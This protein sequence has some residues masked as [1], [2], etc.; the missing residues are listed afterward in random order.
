MK[1][2]LQEL[3]IS[4]QSFRK[5]RANNYLYVDKTKEIFKLAKNEKS[6]FLSRP[7][8]FGKSLLVSTLEN[9]FLGKKELFKDLYIYDKWDWNKTHPVI[10]IDLGGRT[11]RSG[12]K[13]KNSLNIF[14]TKIAKE[15]DI[16][17]EYD[18]Y[19][20]KFGEL[21]ESLVNK[22]GKVVVLIDEYDK[23]ILDN[24]PY[25]NIRNE[26]K[27]VLHDFYQILKSQDDNLRFVFLT[28][29]SKFVGTSIFSGLNNLVDITLSNKFSTICGYTQNELE[30]Y[31]KSYITNLSKEFNIN[32]E[33]A[34]LSIKEWYNGYSWDGKNFVYN[35]QST[36][37]LFG[38]MEFNNYWFKTGTPTFL[39]ELLKGKN[40][41]NK[42]FSWVK[43]GSEIVDAYDPENIPL[44]PLMFQTGY[45]TINEK[46]ITDLRINYLLNIPN[47]EVRD[48][49]IK[50]LMNISMDYPLNQVNSLRNRMRKNF[51]NKN[52]EDLNNNL[53]EMLASIP[54]KL[55]NNNEA[56]FHS[57]FLIWLNLL[58]FKIEGEVVT[59]I[60][61]MDAILIIDDSA[62]II[63][64]KFD[65]DK[66]KLDNLVIKALNQIMDS[67]Y[68]EK[69]LNYDLIFL[70]IAFADKEVK[71]KFKRLDI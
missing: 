28:G 22:H 51:L 67:K 18:D 36:L 39:L 56:Y 48:S 15:H 21:I 7:R 13:L 42:I 30:Y 6:Y 65:K 12:E 35:P 20:D 27:K 61:Q 41:L 54:Y 47:T 3:P 50:Y 46:K 8:R 4:V 37:S 44:I 59:N 26:M 43:S 17:L 64:I 31:F 16:K 24:V 55:Y 63:E 2:E 69:Y 70:G 5:L 68:Y 57:I 38:E 10:R 23:P 9:L 53:R 19:D 14:L 32:V 49:L 33:T 62:I 34:L 40:T 66:N 1:N 25:P 29:V 60:G 58:G 52:S 71:C 45:L 11:H